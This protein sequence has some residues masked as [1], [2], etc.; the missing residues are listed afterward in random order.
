MADIPTK[1]DDISLTRSHVS[2][3]G[4]AR[5]FVFHIEMSGYKFTGYFDT[6]P[7]FLT[8][9]AECGTFFAYKWGKK[10]RVAANSVLTRKVH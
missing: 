7:G 10:T 3:G 2:V 9:V 5:P 8:M 4:H 1:I 6:W